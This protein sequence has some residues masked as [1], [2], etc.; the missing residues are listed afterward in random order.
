MPGYIPESHNLTKSI[1]TKM[2]EMTTKQKMTVHFREDAV[3]NKV[4][5]YVRGRPLPIIP[6]HRAQLTRVAPAG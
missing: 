3:G 2:N 6:V 1:K 5:A 4:G